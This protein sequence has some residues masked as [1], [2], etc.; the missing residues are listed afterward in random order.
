MACV[1]GLCRSIL[2]S[3]TPTMPTPCF[4]IGSFVRVT[5]DHGLFCVRFLIFIL[6][7]TPGAADAKTVV[8]YWSLMIALAPVS[9]IA[10]AAQQNAGAYAGIC[11]A[12]PRCCLALF[13]LTS[14]TLFFGNCFRVPTPSPYW[15]LALG[16]E[17]SPSHS[18]LDKH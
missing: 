6:F 10:T 5:H 18:Y 3:S 13:E 11:A 4:W 8:N 1:L 15:A 12:C 2:R 7:G 17:H 14:F 9:P 16:K